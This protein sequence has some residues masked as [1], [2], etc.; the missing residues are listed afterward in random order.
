MIL[1]E[2]NSKVICLKVLFANESKLDEARGPQLQVEKKSN[3][4]ED[5]LN[6]CC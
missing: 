6:N 4:L 5:N 2:K 3:L 1:H